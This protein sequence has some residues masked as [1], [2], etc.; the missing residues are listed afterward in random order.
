MEIKDLTAY[1]IKTQIKP[2]MKAYPLSYCE[3]LELVAEYAR[4]GVISKDEDVMLHL[5]D[6]I[7]KRPFERH[8]FDI[9]LERNR[10]MQ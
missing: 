7:K 9:V 4:Y 2:D 8:M 1:E 3:C 5:A 10:G 6:T